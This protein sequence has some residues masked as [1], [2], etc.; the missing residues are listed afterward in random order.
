[1]TCSATSS[2][3]SH[4]DDA[5]F[6]AWG[7]ELSAALDALLIFPKSADSSQINWET[8]TRSAVNTAAGYEIRYLNDSLH[9]TKPIYVKIEY[10][11]S[12]TANA[13]GVWITVGKGSDGAGTITNVKQ[14]R[15]EIDGSPTTGYN[16]GTTNSYYCAVDGFVGFIFHAGASV[17]T[18]YIRC[19]AG[20]I[21]QR[22]VDDSGTPTGDGF[23]LHYTSQMGNRAESFS[24]KT[25]DGSYSYDSGRT[26]SSQVSAFFPIGSGRGVVGSSLSN[27]VYRHQVCLD[28]PIYSAFTCSTHPSDSIP[29]GTTFSTNLVGTETR[30]YIQLPLNGIGQPG[31]S[32]VC[33][34]WE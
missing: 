24:A 26:P 3:S 14:S 18:S 15:T 12:S 27:I 23:F 28:L 19:A 31:T 10:G 21:L 9:S 33:M 7:S 13:P 29:E 11:T 5:G 34:I 25:Y 6:R 8:V 30:R 32:T 16:S 4:N 22:T 17:Y 20:M 1:M 2:V